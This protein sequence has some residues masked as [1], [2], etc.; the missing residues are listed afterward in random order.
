MSS[1]LTFEAEITPG[2]AP[3]E[4]VELGC[5]VED[6]GFDRLGISCVALWPDT[7][8]LQTLIAA[9]TDRIQIAIRSG[10]AGPF[11][12]AKAVLCGGRAAS[13]PRCG[14]MIHVIAVFGPARHD[15][16][17]PKVKHKISFKRIDLA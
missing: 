13:A 3:S 2:M 12:R 4:V 17:A 6:A 11:A 1:G 9:R 10:L 14:T 7:Y 8:Q 5:L 15:L 16:R